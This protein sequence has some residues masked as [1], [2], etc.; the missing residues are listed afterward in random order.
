[1]VNPSSS[2]HTCFH[3]FSPNF[4]LP[5]IL[6]HC[7]DLYTPMSVHLSHTCPEYDAEAW[8]LFPGSKRSLLLVVGLQPRQPQDA[9]VCSN[10]PAC[11][12]RISTPYKCASFA[13]YLEVL[14]MPSLPRPGRVPLGAAASRAAAAAASPVP[15]GAAG[16]RR[17]LCAFWAAGSCIPSTSIACVFS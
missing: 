14:A 15:A 5:S 13:V 7:T 12:T 16:A 3:L 2:L 17:C 8:P 1:M 6:M 9:S 10:N 11:S 4:V